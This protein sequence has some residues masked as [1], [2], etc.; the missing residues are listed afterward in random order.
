[1]LREFACG[2]SDPLAAS[3]AAKGPAA[4]AK[5]LRAAR[6]LRNPTSHDHLYE[7][8]AFDEYTAS[9]FDMDHH[10]AVAESA[11]VAMLN[12]T[13][14]SRYMLAERTERWPAD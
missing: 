2:L 9:A 4:Y 7:Q 10:R 5:R 11:L 1:M 6:A 8:D 14:C 3:E 13:S 12:R